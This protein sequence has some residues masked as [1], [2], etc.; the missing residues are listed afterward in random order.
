MKITRM[1]GAGNSFVITERPD[2]STAGLAEL[3]VELCGGSSETRAD[4]LIAVCPFSGD[5]ADFRMLFFNSDG[6]MG[7]MCGN[8]ARCVCRYGYEHGFAPDPQN[9]RVMTT[10]GLVTGRRI[11]DVLYEIRL[12][13]P[14]VLDP[15]R[16]AETDGRQFDCSYVELGRPGIPH[17]VVLT[18]E[19]DF[20]D[21][22]ALRER[23]RQLRFSPVFPKGAN[24]TF[25]YFTGEDSVRAITFERGVEDFTL[26][27]GTGCGSVAV[28]LGARD[29]LPGNSLKISMPGG[30]LSVRFS[31]CGDSFSDIYLTGPTA[32]I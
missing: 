15:H 2:D 26:A 21:L 7:E 31:R 30:E 1:H 3:A 4:G 12:N 19:D 25:A 23:G 11:D 8:G 5:S 6:T 24:V 20:S 13:D 16:I 28:S 29:L 9:I 14:D 27:C 22:D 17:A 10:A 32:Y 18:P